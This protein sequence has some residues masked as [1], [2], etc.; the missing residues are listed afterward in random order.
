MPRAFMMM[1]SSGGSEPSIQA[2]TSPTGR[3]RAT[4]NFSSSASKPSSRRRR[5]SASPPAASVPRSSSG[6]SFVCSSSFFASAIVGRPLLPVALGR[7]VP[8]VL[9]LLNQ[10][11]LLHDVLVEVD[12]R[13]L[14][15]EV[16]VGAVDAGRLFERVL[17][18]RGARVAAHV[19]N[20]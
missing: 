7:V 19:L 4:A 16:N 13:G 3:P 15:A 17:D 18:E 8:D 1:S 9:Y 11:L 12:D 10:R 2:A 14:A 6:L 20:V 5:R